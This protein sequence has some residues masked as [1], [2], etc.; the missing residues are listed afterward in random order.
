MLVVNLIK[1]QQEYVIGHLAYALAGYAQT[2]VLC[3]EWV[4]KRFGIELNILI[5]SKLRMA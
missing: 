5:N 2:I 1:H 3:S 4:S